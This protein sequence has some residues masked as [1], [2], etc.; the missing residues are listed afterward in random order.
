MHQSKLTTARFLLMM[1]I[2]SVGTVLAQTG[3]LH[4]S[5]EPTQVSGQIRYQNGQPANEVIVRLEALA[6]G[7]ITEVRTDRMG[8][9]RIDG[10]SPKQYQIVIR[11]LGYREIRHDV[12]LVMVSAEYV[13]LVLVADG[14]TPR[15]P[16]TNPVVDASVPSAAR[17]ELEKAESDLATANKV[18]LASGVQ[19]L[20]KA[21]SL[22]PNFLDAQLRLGGAYM[23][24]GQWDNAE[25]ALRRALE[26]NPKTANAFFALGELYR[27]T[28]RYADSEKALRAGL[29][30]EDRSWQGHFTLAR[31][32]WD[33]GRAG[34]D[35]EQSRTFFQKA[36]EQCT[37]T[38]ELNPELGGPHLLKANLLLR[39][40]RGPDALK[41][42]EEYLRLEPKGEYAVQV[43]DTVEKLKTP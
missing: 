30:L 9:F 41:E 29:A 11:Q 31:I 40:R 25:R 17:K 14:G 16:A 12:N 2:A 39:A 28:K 33:M 10:L 35:E 22:H 43:R 21:I 42:F 4:S 3:Q 34:T 20:E 37:K 23:D 36:Y 1:L 8:K 7:S 32:Y 26:I 5:S 6:G 24:L 18:K 19:H 15:P 38:L 27:L 13:P